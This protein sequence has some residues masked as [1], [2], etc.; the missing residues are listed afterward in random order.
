[1]ALTCDVCNKILDRLAGENNVPVPPPPA[2]EGQPPPP[3]VRSNM[4]S[5]IP[6]RVAL[7][8]RQPGQS[9]FTE[10][11]KAYL[12]RQAGPFPIDREF[13]VCFECWLRSMGFK[14]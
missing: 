9:E 1:M 10:A 7:A 8:A 4:G 2:V 14:P 3:M 13:N 5:V 12:Q 6:V 11:D